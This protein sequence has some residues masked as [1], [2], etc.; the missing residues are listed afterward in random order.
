MI[1][2]FEDWRNRSIEVWKQKAKLF[3]VE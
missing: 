3:V 1:G 2:R